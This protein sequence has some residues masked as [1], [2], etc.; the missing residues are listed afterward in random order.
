LGQDGNACGENA[1][2]RDDQESELAPHKSISFCAAIFW[3][4]HQPVR[5]RAEPLYRLLPRGGEWGAGPKT[6]R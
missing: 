5:P 4:V 3:A 1:S 6:A 2:K